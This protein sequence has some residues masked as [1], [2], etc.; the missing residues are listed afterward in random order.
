MGTLAALLAAPLWVAAAAPSAP[1]EDRT[2]VDSP[3]VKSPVQP[4]TPQ[5]YTHFVASFDY[6]KHTATLREFLNWRAE[7]NVVV[8]DLRTREDFDRGHVA[9]AVYLGSDIT[10]ERLAALLPDPQTR[11]LV[12]CANSFFPTRRLALTDVA[13]PQIAFLGHPRVWMLEAVWRDPGNKSRS[14]P[15]E[16]EDRPRPW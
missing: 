10:Q 9:G 13:L 12:Y 4:A 8:A 15:W 3:G 5:D 7:K 11:L 6:K 14:I 1:P 2:V 16:G